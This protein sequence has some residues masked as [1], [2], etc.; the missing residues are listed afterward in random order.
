MP[1][2]P[3]PPQHQRSPTL[4]ELARRLVVEPKVAPAA[5]VATLRVD[6]ELR[7]GAAGRLGWP[8]RKGDPGRGTEVGPDTIFDLASVT[9]PLVAVTAARLAHRGLLDLA[10]PLGALLPELIESVSAKVPLEWLLAHRA[11]L[12]AHRTLFA[13]LLA[14]RAVH[15]AQALHVAAA[16]R[17]EDAVAAAPHE[18]FAPLY[19]DLGYVLAGAALERV[20]GLPLDALVRHETT[21]P[22][23]LDEELGSAREWAARGVDLDARIAPTEWAAWRGG[24]VRGAVHDENAWAIAGHGLAGQAGAFGT[25]RA[26]ARFGAAL[27]EALDGRR[28]DYLLAREL[29]ILLKPRA[30]GSLLAGFDGKSGEG[31][32]AG[33]SASARSFGHLGFTGTSLWCDPERGLVSVA[34]TNRVC[35]TREHL[36]LRTLRPMLHEAL[37]AAA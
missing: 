35:P 36:A 33:P 30:G 25:A 11:G 4:D 13:P 24:L 32:S 8:A 23:G 29:Q 18:G 5:S 2:S 21:A 7:V 22:L 14:G 16:A 10:T 31:S 17:R 12:A 6:G 26:V 1:E 9:K 34:L 19:S 27:L 15:R 37:F 20:S 3:P 28:P